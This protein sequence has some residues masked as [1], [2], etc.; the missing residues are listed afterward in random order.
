MQFCRTAAPN[1]CGL[2]GGG[3]G[4]G[5][6]STHLSLHERQGSVHAQ[7]NLRKLSCAHLCMRAAH[8]S[9]KSSCAHMR[10]HWPAA[11]VAQL[12]IGHGP[13]VAAAW[14]LWTPAVETILL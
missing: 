14:G 11:H 1:L 9:C 8:C 3:R 12:Q 2:V 10:A 6:A 4:T 5:H 7:L 13:E